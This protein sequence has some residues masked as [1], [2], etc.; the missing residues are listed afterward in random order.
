LQGHSLGTFKIVRYLFEGKYADKIN[1]LILL[2]PFDIKTSTDI[3]KAN[4]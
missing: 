3:N 4:D 2:A 1:K